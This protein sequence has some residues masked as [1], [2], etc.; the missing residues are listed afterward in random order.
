MDKKKYS[1]PNRL[2]DFQ[3]FISPNP[4]VLEEGSNVSNYDTFKSNTND[5]ISMICKQYGTI[6][7]RV[8][9]DKIKVKSPE[10]TTFED[11]LFDQIKNMVENG[12]KNNTLHVT[13]NINALVNSVVKEIKE[14]RKEDKK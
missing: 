11:T 7:Y 14:T 13:G 10:G 9:Q 12:V 2:V 8:L 4:I 3:T 6:D 5:I 1:N